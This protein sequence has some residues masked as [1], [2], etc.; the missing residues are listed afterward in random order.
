MWNLK[1]MPEASR[2]IDTHWKYA[3][4]SYNFM[5][6]ST[7]TA[8]YFV[9]QYGKYIHNTFKPHYFGL[10]MYFPPINDFSRK[11]FAMCCGMRKP[12]ELKVRHC[13]ACLI[14]INDYLNAL[15]GAK[16]SDNIGETDI[17]KI[18]LNSIPNGWIK[19]VYVQGFYCE[20]ITKNVN[21]FERMKTEKKLW[22]RC[23]IFSQ[24][25]TG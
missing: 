4:S 15:P 2:M 7:T 22:R 24:K 19:Q 3:A 23:R 5:W 6:W 1:V 8:W 16:S 17:D 18:L 12:R 20:T 9:C 10:G 25:F 13:A 11:K 21:M 14:D